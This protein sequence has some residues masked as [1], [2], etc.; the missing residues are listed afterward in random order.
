MMLQS[1]LEGGTV[2]EREHKR[3]VNG[4]G[5]VTARPNSYQPISP[6]AHA[7]AGRNL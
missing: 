4:M 5:T 7:E 6:T 3:G 1:G 2:R